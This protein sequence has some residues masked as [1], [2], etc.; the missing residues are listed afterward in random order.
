MK[1][2]SL[3]PEET[4]WIANALAHNGQ[5]Q[6][7]Y[8]FYET[9]LLDPDTRVSTK[10]DCLTYFFDRGYSNISPEGDDSPKQQVIETIIKFIQSSDHGALIN[11]ALRGL[12]LIITQKALEE[13]FMKEG[14]FETLVLLQEKRRG[15]KLGNSD[16][17][18]Y[19][20]LVVYE[21]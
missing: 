7:L 11:Y 8:R 9:L 1:P 10:H 21:G 13:K 17:K 18:N 3:T 14:S 19:P 6:I 15:S 2:F 5:Y 4:A 16:P 20:N 12:D